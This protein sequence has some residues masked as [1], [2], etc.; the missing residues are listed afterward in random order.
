M[1]ART[2]A[3]AVLSVSALALTAGSAAAA[4]NASFD[5]LLAETTVAAAHADSLT[6]ERTERDAANTSL[7]VARSLAAQGNTDA[8]AGYL[9]FARGKLGLGAVAPQGVVGM[10]ASGDVISHDDAIASHSSYR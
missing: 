6:A 10:S 1:F 2:L 4:Q 8:A 5:A 7:S 9:N 3:A